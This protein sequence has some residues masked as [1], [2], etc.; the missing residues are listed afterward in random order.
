MKV[1]QLLRGYTSGDGVSNVVDYFKQTFDR[2]GVESYIINRC[3]YKEDINEGWISEDDILFYHVA[4]DVEP[5]IRYMK[6]KKIMVFHNITDPNLM[7]GS[8]FEEIRVRCAAGLYEIRTIDHL[9]DAA[10]VFSDYSKRTLIESGWNADKIFNIPIKVMLDRFSGKAAETVLERYSDGCTNILFTG[11]VAIHKRFEDIIKTFAAYKEKYNLNS[12][13]L[14]VGSTSDKE[15]LQALLNLIRKLGIEDSVVF[16]GHVSFSEYLA[17]YKVA[18]VFLCM[19]AHEGFC[20]PLVEAMYFGIPIVASSTTAIPDTLGGCGVLVDTRNPDTIAECINRLVSDKEYCAQ[21]VSGEKKRLTG[22]EGDAL[23]AEYDETL[24]KCIDLCS[25][26]TDSIV[27]ETPFVGFKKRK[28]CSELYETSKKIVIYGNGAACE[29]LLAI[30]KWEGRHIELICD[31]KAEKGEFKNGEYEVCSLSF[32]KTRFPDCLFIISVQNKKIIF[33][34]IKEMSLSGI[35][36]EN[37]YIFDETTESI[38]KM[39]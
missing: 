3:L 32:A 4:V 11:R 16:T 1:I 31:K 12:R 14:L 25:K 34:I 17:F 37:I 6:C 36:N 21:V 33:E 18:N 2:L 20:I 7:I 28:I 30:L 27:D 26:N 9:F 39:I 19:S 13:L 38:F 29:N 23:D 5:F 24:K 22:L 8:G 10:I 35:D 15:Y